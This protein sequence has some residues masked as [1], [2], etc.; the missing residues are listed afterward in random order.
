MLKKAAIGF[1]VVLG[2]YLALFYGIE[3]SRVRKGPWE[4]EFQ[5]DGGVPVL[6]IRQGHLGVEEAR[7]RFPGGT[8]PE[9]FA[10]SREVFDR[11][12]EVPFQTGFAKVFYEDLTFLPGVVT[13]HVYGHELEMLPRTFFVDRKEN[14]WKARMEFTLEAIQEELPDISKNP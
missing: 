4:V 5:S 12:M 10:P 3:H 11:P 2:I 8:L 9:D 1:L 6:V 13:L 14:P 7:L